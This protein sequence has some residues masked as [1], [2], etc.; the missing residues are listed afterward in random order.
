MEDNSVRFMKAE[1]NYDYSYVTDNTSGKDD[2][3]S[4]E[5]TPQDMDSG[6]SRR[7]PGHGGHGGGHRRVFAVVLAAALGV[8]AGVG[9]Y[10]IAKANGEDEVMASVSDSTASD[11]GDTSES[12]DSSESS[13]SDLGLQ[14][15]DE[16]VEDTTITK[17]V[18]E[19]MPSIVAIVNSFTET[20]QSWNG[21]TQSSEAEAAGSGIII[22]ETDDELLIVTNNHVVED[23]DSLKVQFVDETT[24]DA[25][26]KG[27][28]SDMDLAVI[29]VSLDD[30][31]D[32]TKDA[33]SIATLGNSDNLQVG[34]T[35]IA[36]GN[37]LGYGQSVTTG[38]VS[39]VDREIESSDGTTSNK[40]I[41][42]D[43]AIN[44]GN[45]GGALIDMNGN[46]I[47][48]N[49]AKTS[50]TTVEGMGYAI[51]ISDAIPVIEE[52]MN[53]TT[54]TVVDEAD[55]GVI[56]IQGVSV[57]SQVAAAYNMPEGVYVAEITEGSGADDSD[58]Q[59]GDIITKIDGN[60]VT[61]I[62]DL[63]DKLRYY[64]AGTEV[65][66][67]V[68]RAD[69]DGNYSEVEITLT[70]GSRSDATTSSSQTQKS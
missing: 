41:Q 27:T 58:L 43:A 65:T 14:I 22:G 48:I 49:V 54:K 50:D 19:D 15:S 45:S 44:P 2:A 3:G 70:L 59:K 57:T 64:E 66:L 25:N 56:G 10:S 61:D 52:L 16:T 39:A 21:Q 63:Q 26:I 47:G 37:A 62:S 34:Q 38:V 32:D 9:S 36:I 29:A 8:A 42:T 67:T 46:V 28:D 6:S 68:E 18:E 20:S 5:G 23:E 24:A 33:I 31:S 30:L 60:T 69:E 55:R 4:H 51:P 53:E 11:T 1:G 17:I 13:E 7:K 40:Y 12:S 35:V